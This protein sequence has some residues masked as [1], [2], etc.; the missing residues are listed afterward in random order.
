MHSYFIFISSSVYSPHHCYDC[1]YYSN[2]CPYLTSAGLKRIGDLYKRHFEEATEEVRR[3][4]VVVA[5]TKEASLRQIS[6]LR[7]SLQTLGMVTFFFLS[8][9]KAAPL[10]AAL[11]YHAQSKH[12]LLCPTIV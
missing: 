3:L 8:T 2:I 7:D 5:E 6:I 9:T 11:L 4:E 12:I 10:N 1:N